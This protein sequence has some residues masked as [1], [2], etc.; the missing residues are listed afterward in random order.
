MGDGACADSAH[1]DTEVRESRGKEAVMVLPHIRDV[2][3]NGRSR[4]MYDSLRNDLNCS[5]QGFLSSP[6][7]FWPAWK[8]SFEDVGD[9][10]TPEVSPVTADVIVG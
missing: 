8:G 4:C 7:R 3:V 2:A 9:R 6:R 1:L 5:H 10:K